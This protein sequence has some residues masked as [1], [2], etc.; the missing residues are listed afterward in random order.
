MN[1]GA[2]QLKA[3]LALWRSWMERRDP[4]SITHQIYQMLWEDA[5]FRV[6]NECRR[7]APRSPEGGAQLNR[8]IHEFINNGYFRTQ[9]IMI[10]RL[11]ERNKDRNPDW[12]VISLRR[13]LDDIEESGHLYTRGNIFEAEGLPYDYSEARKRANDYMLRE[14]L[15]PDAPVSGW[16]DPEIMDA[17]DRPARLHAHLDRMSGTTPQTRTPADALRK[18]LIPPLRARLDVCKGVKTYVDKIVAHAADPANRDAVPVGDPPISLG[19]I[20][21]CH[22][23]ICSRASFVSVYLL[24]GPQ[25]RFLAIPQFNALEYIER[26]WISPENVGKLQD[27]WDEQDMQAHEW[28]NPV[29]PEEWQAKY[30]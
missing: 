10:R 13:L 27:V 8:L 25:L 20:W 1:G 9:A 18:D 24:R 17:A 2:E 16:L 12:H 29:W 6:I 30:F 14:A 5:I 26:P 7:L 11:C 4:H 28:G 21:D 19:R 23:A 15:K 22:K 3:K